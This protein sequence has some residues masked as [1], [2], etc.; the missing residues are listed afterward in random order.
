M[1]SRKWEVPKKCDF[2]IGSSYKLGKIA[3]LE[4]WPKII[5]VCRSEIGMIDTYAKNNKWAKT[6]LIKK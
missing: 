3:G 1:K 6:K 5:M 4:K 2:K